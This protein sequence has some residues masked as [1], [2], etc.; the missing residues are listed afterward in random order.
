MRPEGLIGKTLKKADQKAR[1]Q[2]LEEA[3][4]LQKQGG[5]PGEV[6]AHKSGSLPAPENSLARQAD[7][8]IYGGDEK[9]RSKNNNSSRAINQIN[10][11]SWFEPKAFLD[12]LKPYINRLEG[13][14]FMAFSM[15][16]GHVYF[17][18]KV[19]EKVTRKLAEK[20]GAMDIATMADKDKS[21]QNVLFSVVEQFRSGH[22]MIARD[23]IN[24]Q[25]FGGYFTIKMQSGKTMKGYFT[26]F[27]AEAFGS[28]AELENNKKDILKNF[29]SVDVYQS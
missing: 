17:Q 12:E 8:D 26:P 3:V 24:D 13:R 10:I 22:D 25:Y 28:I 4:N 6:P 23:L 19:I 16:G 20:A 14:R 21:M 27:K 2:E 7:T 1:Q 15:P 29:V 5:E 9:S 18:P 11:S